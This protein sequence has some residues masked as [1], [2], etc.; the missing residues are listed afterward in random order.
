MLP[1]LGGTRRPAQPQPPSQ[2]SRS[3]RKLAMAQPCG[4]LLLQWGAPLIRGVHRAQLP[5]LGGPGRG[6]E[7]TGVGERAA[8]RPERRKSHPCSSLPPAPPSV[9]SSHGPCVK[10]TTSLPSSARLSSERGREEKRA[11][12]GEE[13]RPMEGPLHPSRLLQGPKQQSHPPVALSA[14]IIT[15]PGAARARLGCSRKAHR[16]LGC[17]GCTYPK[18]WWHTGERGPTESAAPALFCRSFSPWAAALR[19]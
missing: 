9:T 16:T 1:R 4:S 2:A 6:E 8:G 13:R 14:H 15:R 10:A 7:R 12:A 11:G 19:Q 5:H 18:S 3:C 17:R